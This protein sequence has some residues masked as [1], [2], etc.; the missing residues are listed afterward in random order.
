MWGIWAMFLGVDADRDADGYPD[1][2]LYAQSD[3]GTDGDHDTHGDTGQPS[4]LCAEVG[5]SGAG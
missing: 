4:G 3:T 5:L 2:D 1:T